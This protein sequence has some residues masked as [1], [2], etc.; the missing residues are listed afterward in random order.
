MVF[1]KP[2]STGNINIPGRTATEYILYIKVILL[3]NFALTI[4]EYRILASIIV[5]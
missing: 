3:I 1:L 4:L 2:L 5:K